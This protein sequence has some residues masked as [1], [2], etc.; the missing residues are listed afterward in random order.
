V[1]YGAWSWTLTNELDGA[2]MMWKRKIQRKIYGPTY[3]NGLLENKNNQEIYNKFKY[4]YLVT[5]IKVGSLEWFGHVVRLDL[6]G[7]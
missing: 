1:T 6:K 5:V 2:L 3:I 4:P 7:K